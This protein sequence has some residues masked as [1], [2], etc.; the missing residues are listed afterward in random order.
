MNAVSPEFFT[1]QAAVAGRYSLVG[2]IGRGGMGIV[3]AARD[4]ALDRPVAIK[5]LPPA[6]AASEDSRRRFL[7]EARTAASLSHPH[8][9][10][11]H[12][13]EERHGL[14]FFVMTLVEGESLGARVRRLGALPPREAMRVVQE[15]AW[16]LG[17]AHAR[18]VV[19]RDVKPDNI[20]LDRDGDRA[21]VTDFGIAHAVG[22]DTPVDGVMLGTPAYMSPEQGRGEEPDARSDIYALGVTA[23]M[24]AAGRLPFPGPDANAYF[25]QHASMDVPPLASACAQLAP[26]FARAIDQCLAK[27]PAD[28][29]SSAEALAMA[30][31]DERSRLP[32]V[33]APV[34]AY[35]REWDRV[36]AEVATAGTAA[37]VAGVLGLVMMA[38][39]SAS[40]TASILAAVYLLV[41][42][43]MGAI[44]AERLAQLGVH[45]RLLLRRGYDVRSLSP[46]MQRELPERAEEAHSA[47]PGEGRAAIT[48]GLVAFAVGAASVWGLWQ[49]TNELA[50]IVLATMSVVAPTVGVRTLW[51]HLHR[52][53]PEGLWNRLA[54]GWLGRALFRLAAL[55][56]DT[57]PLP[58]TDGGE[59]T[60][61]AIGAQARRAFAALPGAEREQLREVP[62]IVEQLEREAMLLRAVEAT[63]AT[64]ARLASAMAALDLLRLDLL[65]LGSGHAGASELTAAIDRVREIGFRVDA[66]EEV[67]RLPGKGP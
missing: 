50:T 23:W 28:R 67:N 24:A 1:L 29:W 17:H 52:G 30:L 47:Q 3:F 60:V 21:L 39:P 32:A 9:V 44:A 33:P 57:I 59:P 18:G 13:V 5:L 22:R 4:V 37:G 53:N 15:V 20:L 26:A 36:G 46:A 12:A 7:R 25:V 19:H 35:L 58:L 65:K 49:E 45:A 14:V 8:I 61:L 31:A 16:A 56:V 48:T 42:A 38:L 64:G 34:R 6:L 66:I 11:I 62:A 41:S 55:G 51:A 10:P 63:P 2:E 43:L 54:G 40:F 27:S